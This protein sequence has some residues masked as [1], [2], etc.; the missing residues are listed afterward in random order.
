MRRRKKRR[1]GGA[2]LTLGVEA[3]LIALLCAGTF[4]IERSAGEQEIEMVRRAVMRCI[5]SCYAIEGRYP[6]SLDYLKQNYGLRYDGNQYI[7]RYDA[8][9]DNQLPDVSVLEKEAQR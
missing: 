7:V 5:A 1:F 2:A 9:A 8:F 3:L 4:R 6:E